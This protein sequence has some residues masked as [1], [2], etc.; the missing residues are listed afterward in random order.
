[1]ACDLFAEFLRLT[2][3]GQC[4]AEAAA[5]F[6][7]MKNTANAPVPKPGKAGPKVASPKRD[8]D[9]AISP[10]NSHVSWDW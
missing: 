6:A 8:G 4:E 7:A 9:E 5:H 2:P 3:A 10:S 1:V